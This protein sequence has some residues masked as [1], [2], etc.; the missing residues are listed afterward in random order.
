[1]ARLIRALGG[2]LLPVLAAACL[3]VAGDGPATAPPSDAPLPPDGDAYRVRPR[4]AAK[5]DPDT[6]RFLRANRDFF[7]ARLD[8]LHLALRP[9]WSGP[10][11][12]FDPEWLAW[13]QMLREIGAARDSAAAGEEAIRR[14]GLLDSV[15][16]LVDLEKQM[17][18]MEALLDA[19]GKRLAR[20]EEDFSGEQ[21]TALVVLLTGVSSHGL[22]GTV[23]LWDDDGHAHRSILSPQIRTALEHG[24][25]TELLH[26]LVEP[27]AQHWDV[28]LEGEGWSEM[29]PAGIELDPERHRLTFVEVDLS[30]LDA[31]RAATDADGVF[32]QW[33]R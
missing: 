31:G 24:G 28:A 1:V 33:V 3:A 26:C 8:E 15:G 19:Q 16:Q 5:H 11:E 18:E 2:A 23:V 10:A 4:D 7:R 9:D 30:A 29:L 6:L 12:P 25:S 27:R 13:P 17:D 21:S 22:P 20:L 14:Q 32:R